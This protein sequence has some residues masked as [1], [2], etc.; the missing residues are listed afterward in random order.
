MSWNLAL[1]RGRICWQGLQRMMPT[2]LF[3]GEFSGKDSFAGKQD[4]GQKKPCCG[5]FS[6]RP[7]RLLWFALPAFESLLLGWAPGWALA[8]LVWRGERHCHQWWRGGRLPVAPGLLPS[9]CCLQPPRQS[10]APSSHLHIS[11][12][13]SPLRGKKG[14]RPL[15]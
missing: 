15:V 4:R 7:S 3:P 2:W 13:L 11:V 10:F 9:F 14:K 5:L 6:I 1:F 12:L 8:K